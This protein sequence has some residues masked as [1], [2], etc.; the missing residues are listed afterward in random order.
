MRAPNSLRFNATP[1]EIVTALNDL[2]GDV[3]DLQLVETPHIRWEHQRGG[4]GGFVKVLGHGE[5]G[6]VRND[7][8]SLISFDA[9]SN[10]AKI[11]AGWFFPSNIDPVFV[12]AAEVQVG[13]A[14]VEYV[15]AEY[16]IASATATIKDSTVAVPPQYRSNQFVRIV[17]HTFRKQAN[18]SMKHD[19]FNH[20]GDHYIDVL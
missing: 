19:A 17:L 4:V 14:L 3:R 10:V 16:D 18:D 6:G 8:F 12:D 1:R 11:R 7:T 15:I 5:G 13:S 9:A 20:P 2:L